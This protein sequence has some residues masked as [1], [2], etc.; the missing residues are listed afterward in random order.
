M[1]KIKAEGEES[2]KAKIRE[3]RAIYGS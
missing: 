3:I 2:K 1:N